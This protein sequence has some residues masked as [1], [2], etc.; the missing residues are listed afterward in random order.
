MQAIAHGWKPRGPHASDMPSVSV[1]RE[2]TAADKHMQDKD[3]AG[4][5]DSARVRALRRSR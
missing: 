4:H 1:A 2:M 3:Q 5:G